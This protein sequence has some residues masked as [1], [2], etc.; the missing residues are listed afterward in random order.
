MAL[1]NAVRKDSEMEE[2]DYNG[3][4]KA[5]DKYVSL[6]YI[7]DPKWKIPQGKIAYLLEPRTLGNDRRSDALLE[8]M[9][10]PELIT[11]VSKAI[12]KRTISVLNSIHSAS[13]LVQNYLDATYNAYQFGIKENVIERVYY[14]Y[15]WVRCFQNDTALEVSF[16]TL[17]EYRNHRRAFKVIKLIPDDL[18][19][20]V[21]IL[22]YLEDVW[23]MPSP[24][25]HIE[26]QIYSYLPPNKGPHDPNETVICCK[27]IF[28]SFVRQNFNLE[29]KVSDAEIG[30]IGIG[31][32]VTTDDK[33]PGRVRR[34][35]L[36]NVCY[37]SV[38]P[39]LF[40]D[41]FHYAYKAYKALT[42]METYRDV[43][44]A[45]K[46]M[47]KKRKQDERQKQAKQAYERF[48]MD[49]ARKQ[50]IRLDM[51]LEELVRQKKKKE[52]LDAFMTLA[53]K[54]VNEK[55]SPE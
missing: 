54:I 53:A 29:L 8:K 44:F 20:E 34:K 50:G 9:R 6:S 15:P 26:S 23:K 3:L 32:L 31:E 11:F 1:I 33:K 2:F 10:I 24:T 13:M 4:D 28:D 51:S 43:F 37:V 25:I 48:L 30:L 17:V 14:F 12:P 36:E 49:F 55:T 46:R 39:S 47:C 19:S 45:Y 52:I 27:S 18:S 5:G 38:T 41:Y 40:D 42:Y 16:F 22:E 35:L 7:V 21:S